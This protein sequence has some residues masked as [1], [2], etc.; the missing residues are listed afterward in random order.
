[1]ISVPPSELHPGGIYSCLESVMGFIVKTQEIMWASMCSEDGP[2][3]AEVGLCCSA[4]G[5]VPIGI[6]Q[7]LCGP[8]CPSSSCSFPMIS[9]IHPHA[10]LV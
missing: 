5:P 9:M 8:M 6:K 2:N 4:W 1:M 10:K 7:P 3:R